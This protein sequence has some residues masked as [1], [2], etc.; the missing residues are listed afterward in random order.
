M[1]LASNSPRRKEI[2]E[3]LGFNLKIIPANITEKSDEKNILEKIKDIAYK[4]A[5]FIAEKNKT[6]FVLAA[7][8]IVELDGE[9]L[10]KPRDKEEIYIY[11]KKL[12]GK[13]HRVITAYSLI[14]MEKNIHIKENSISEV[15]FYSL[16]DEDIEWYIDTK[17]PFDK[18]GAYGIQGK[19][20]VFV[21]RIS[22]DF[23]S[24]MGFPVSQFL[25]TLAELG[26]K[27]NNINKI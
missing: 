19:G 26:Y 10:G 1:I 27:I 4:K 24:I 23:Y 2:L 13:T 22:G 21:K 8:T 18:A 6:D 12:S 14:N 15:E 9:I 16:T 5:L 3:N 20:R 7:D 17:E 11:L 25:K